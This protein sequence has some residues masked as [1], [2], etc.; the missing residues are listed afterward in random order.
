MQ[1]INISE[2]KAKCLAVLEEIARTGEGVTI[3]KRGK[4]I[5]QVLPAT[6]RRSAYPQLD[7]RGT[8][9][10]LGDIVAPA[11]PASHWEAAEPEP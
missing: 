4:P 8:V 3:L 9:E 5:A 11:L 2:F 1:S 6:P 10:V 7:L